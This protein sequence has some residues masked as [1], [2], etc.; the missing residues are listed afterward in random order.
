MPTRREVVEVILRDHF[1]R[2][3]AKMAAAAELFNREL[4][5]MSRRSRTLDQRL[6]SLTRHDMSNLH[7][8]SR[9]LGALSGQTRT[10]SNDIDRL[11]GR[12]G[13]AR[14]AVL[15]FGSAVVPLGAAA[16]PVL[17]GIASQLGFAAVA[18]VSAMVAFRGVGEGLQALN[19]ARLEPTAQNLAA[20]EDALRNM[21]PAAAEF[22]LQLDSMRDSAAE[23]REAAAEG[24]FPGLTEALDTIESR[25]P[26]A[27]AIMLRVNRAVGAMTADGAESLASNR[28][29]DF[30]AFL[31]NDAPESLTALG[32]AVGNT[33]HALAELWMAFDPVNDDF[34][35][36]MV[37][38][39]AK[40]DDWASGLADTEGF[41]EFVSYLRESGPQ[42]ADA[43]G[44]VARAI[45]AIVTAAAPVGQVVLPILTALGDTIRVI[46]ESHF[47]TPLI[48]GAAAMA[49][50]SRARNLAMGSAAIGQVRTYGTTLRQT[51]ATAF[52]FGATNRQQ[53][54][55]QQAAMASLRATALQG[56]AAIGAFALVSS[57]AADKLGVTNTA[58]LAMVGAM[59][60]VPGIV[61][62]A[63]VGAFLDLKAAADDTN[64]ATSN[65]KTV[66]SSWDVG[67]LPAAIGETSTQLDTLASKSKWA[68]MLGGLGGLTGIT[69]KLTGM[70]GAADDAS[71]AIDDAE[72]QMTSAD[73]IARAL[74]TSM[75]TDLPR[76]L[77]EAA[78]NSEDY[79]AAT[80]DWTAVI[81]AAQPAMD[82][83]GISMAD[84]ENAQSAQS[85]AAL[86]SSFGVTSANQAAA[87]AGPTL[88]QY[89]AAIAGWN[90]NADSMSGRSDAVGSALGRIDDGMLRTADSAR[91]LNAALD[92]LI[93]PNLSL[94][95]A[96]DAW[97]TSLRSLGDSLAKNKTLVGDSNAAITNRAAINDRV[98]SLTQ[99]INAQAEAG[100]SG[101]EISQTLARGTQELLDQGQAAGLSRQQLR[102]YIRQMGL[103]PKLVRTVIEA[104][105]ADAATKKLQNLA[106]RYR[107]LPKN[108]R[109][110]VEANGIPKSEAGMRRLKKQFDLT[111]RQVQTLVS[112]RD[113]AT[114]RGHSIQKLLRAIDKGKATAK[115]GATSRDFDVRSSKVDSW[116]RK[117]KGSNPSTD[118]KAVDRASAV[119]DRINSKPVHDKSL[120]I[121]TY[122]RTVKLKAT[123]GQVL[124]NV[125]GMVRGPGGPEDDKILTALSNREWVHPVASGDYYGN[126]IMRAI[127]YRTIPREAFYGF[128]PGMATGGQVGQPVRPVTVRV[129][130]ATGASGSLRV[131]VA[132]VVTGTID[133]PF[134]PA[135][136][137]G[138]LRQVANAEQAA[139]EEFARNHRGRDA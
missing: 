108:V 82:A 41:A 39:T 67:A 50:F 58:T 44:S 56:A 98:T 31:E 5:A 71:T 10:T 3:A 119:I 25:A 111:P 1:T 62:G 133:T 74:A 114:A 112:M 73:T 77:A 29:D 7:G 93:S 17:T 46:A 60:G 34:A 40:L 42:A 14:D 37:D 24:L 88:Q 132:G 26:E 49:A 48:A 69:Q 96:T 87:A 86:M 91:E 99:L 137:R 116:Q 103:T 107:G 27:E 52:A 30:F 105:G 118:I 64:V 19:K 9:D 106:F 32:Q 13:L 23:L 90:R 104:S 54:Q 100:K 72:Q 113:Q 110:H 70:S 43:L 53:V 94:Q 123:G 35:T 33:S 79:A 115:I 78:G 66:M 130:P 6:D 136:I 38:A 80:K 127:Q 131:D 102:S 68:G 138:E 18:G 125:R 20:A 83:L 2:E 92:A 101:A 15:T 11:S 81:T 120:T 61:G 89:A 55:Q 117:Y 63:V 84:L 36:S 8:A 4:S 51:A 75:G 65:L 126:A 47:G 134:G 16:I 109:T 59:Y 139:N 21:P 135:K 95:Q 122:E 129:A 128:V 97:T 85:R 12:L 22:V 45:I 121:T 57:G 124:R 76:S 28:W